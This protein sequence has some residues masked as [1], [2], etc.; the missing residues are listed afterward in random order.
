MDRLQERIER[1]LDAATAHNKAVS[2]DDLVN[3]LSPEFAS[4]YGQ[5]DVRHAV[6]MAIG[7]RR[8][9]RL[10]SAPSLFKR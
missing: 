2:D 1:E 6:I 8:Q 7:R 4:I 9:Q 5:A 3:R 10:L